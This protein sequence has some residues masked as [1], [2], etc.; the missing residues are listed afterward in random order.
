MESLAGASK[1]LRTVARLD[2]PVDKRA[3]RLVP[4]LIGL[5]LL[6][7]VASL[8]ARFEAGSPLF[9]AGPGC[10]RRAAAIGMLEH[11]VG[12]LPTGRAL[13]WFSLGLARS[14]S[15]SSCESE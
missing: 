11:Y 2:A 3:G 10:V 5:G 6:P 15:T 9:R 4:A 13:F 1:R 14:G 8:N 12:T 7:L